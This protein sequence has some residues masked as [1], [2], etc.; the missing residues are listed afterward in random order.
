MEN[1]NFMIYVGVAENPEQM[2]T[3]SVHFPKLQKTTKRVSEN[4]SGTSKSNIKKNFRS[5]DQPKS[6]AR[7]NI[8]KSSI[9]VNI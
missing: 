7:T 3:N 4:P 6:Y 9:L 5:V 2:Q 8:N 1:L